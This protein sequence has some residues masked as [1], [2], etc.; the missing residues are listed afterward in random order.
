MN[1][2]TQLKNYSTKGFTLIEL[3]ISISIIALLTGV[4]VFNQS[5]FADKL[6]LT[7]LTSEI[8]LQIREAQTYGISVREFAPGTNNF[9]VA[10]GVSFNLGNAGS[11][12]TSFYSFADLLPQN[13]YFD[14]PTLCQPGPSSECLSRYNLVRGNT[15]TDTCVIQ[16]SGDTTCRAGIGRIDI[17]FV[18]PNP[19]AKITLFNNAGSVV[20]SSYPGFRGVKLEFTS[21]QGKKQDIIVYGTGQISIQ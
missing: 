4:V 14:T 19:T 16:V 7:N 12:N 21:P 10:Y 17:V 20:N 18:R 13:G 15:L 6:A 8:S 2:K 5:D 9:N 3:L 11:S 1:I